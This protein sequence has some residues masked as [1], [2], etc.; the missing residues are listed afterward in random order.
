MLLDVFCVLIVVV[1]CLL[2]ACWYLLC[3]ACC[4]FLRVVLLFIGC[5][6]FLLLSFVACRLLGSVFLL[7]LVVCYVKFVVCS[8]FI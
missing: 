2:F 8:C 4:L 1:C 3:V 6:M 7:L 5:C